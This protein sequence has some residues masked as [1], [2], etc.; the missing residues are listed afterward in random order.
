MYAADP[1][2]ERKRPMRGKGDEV[3]R[4]WEE[5]LDSKG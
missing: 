1:L 2:D 5:L 4:Q 3:A